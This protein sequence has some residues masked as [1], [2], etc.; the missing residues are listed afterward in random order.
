VSNFYGTEFKI[1][2]GFGPVGKNEKKMGA[3]YEQL[4]R[5]GNNFYGTEYE[6]WADFRPV[7]N[8]EKKKIGAVNEQLL[9]PVF[10]MFSW[11]KKCY[12]FFKTIAQ[13]ALKSCIIS[14]F[15][16]LCIALLE[17]CFPARLL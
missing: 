16:N 7:G 14:L 11:A 5:A 8:T 1:W 3:N 9:R 17:T 2:A 13:S 15:G 6:I 10:F 12:H 4:V